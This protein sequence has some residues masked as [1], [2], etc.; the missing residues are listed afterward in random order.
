MGIGWIIAFIVGMLLIYF[1]RHIAGSDST[2]GIFYYNAKIFAGSKE[3]CQSWIENKIKEE[4]N[5]LLKDMQHKFPE[6]NFT[7]N[8]MPDEFRQLEVHYRQ[9][10]KIIRLN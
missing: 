10:H 9:Y 2:Y 8:D 7:K 6:R 4:Q 3:E 1:V 5:K